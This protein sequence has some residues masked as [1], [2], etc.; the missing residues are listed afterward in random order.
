MNKNEEFLGLQ[1]KQKQSETALYARL[2]ASVNALLV[3]CAQ[4]KNMK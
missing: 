4:A 3:H 1:A 2:P